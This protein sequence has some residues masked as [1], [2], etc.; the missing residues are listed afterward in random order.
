MHLRALLGVLKGSDVRPTTARSSNTSRDR[1]EAFDI[2]AKTIHQLME[3]LKS[4]QEAYGCTNKALS[5]ENRTSLPCLGKGLALSGWRPWNWNRRRMV[6]P[7][8]ALS[9]ENWP[10]TFLRRSRLSSPPPQNSQEMLNKSTS[11]TTPQLRPTPSD[12]HCCGSLSSQSSNPPFPAANPPPA[13]LS[14]NT[15]QDKSDDYVPKGNNGFHQENIEQDAPRKGSSQASRWQ[16]PQV[17]KLDRPCH[18]QAGIRGTGWLS[19]Q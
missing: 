10:S 14:P 12:E 4:E 17:S 13:L 16:S 1:R 5:E 3:A 6:V 15:R 2:P 9:G 18:R 7:N 19:L 11:F 8:Q